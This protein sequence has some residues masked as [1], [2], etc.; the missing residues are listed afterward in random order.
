MLKAF[1]TNITPAQTMKLFTAP[2]DGRLKWPEHY[3]YLVAVSEACGGGVDYLI[4][5]NIVQYASA[6]LRTV[7]MAKVDAAR[8][9]YLQQAEELAHF[10]Q[11]WELEPF[12]LRNLGKE[13]VG[14]VSDLRGTETR[15]CHECGE[16]SH[17][18]TACSNRVRGHGREA[19]LTLDVHKA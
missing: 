16:I 5:N 14:A 1:K 13:V 17:L 6:D 9:D 12:R 7:L 11:F 18:N 2:K 8:T 10:A 4:L 19:G 3:I 15:S